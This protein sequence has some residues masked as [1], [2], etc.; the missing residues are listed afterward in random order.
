M[1]RNITQEW[2]SFL[3]PQNRLEADYLCDELDLV[4]TSI[5]NRNTLPKNDNALSSQ[6]RIVHEFR[7]QN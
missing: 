1:K 3:S 5:E 6:G 4:C 2:L 7:T